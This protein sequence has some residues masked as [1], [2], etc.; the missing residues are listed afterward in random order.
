MVR[1]LLYNNGREEAWPPPIRIRAACVLPNPLRQ[2]F[3]SSLFSPSRPRGRGLGSFQPQGT[4]NLPV[5]TGYYCHISRG[6]SDRLSAWRAPMCIFYRMHI[7]ARFFYAVRDCFP[8]GHARGETIPQSACGRQLPL[9][10]GA[11]GYSFLP[12]LYPDERTSPDILPPHPGSLRSPIFPSK[13][14]ASALLPEASLCAEGAIK[15]VF[16]VTCAWQIHPDPPILPQQ[17]GETAP[18]RGAYLSKRSAAFLTASFPSR[19][20]HY[21][22]VRVSLLCRRRYRIC[23]S[24]DMRRGKTR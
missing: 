1:V 15:F 5:T 13:G 18:Q 17:N 3:Q 10:K 6:F 7:G 21:L 16:A 19:G 22:N 4:G 8:A 11:S 9:H 24:T 20:R 23:F 2:N 14:K 12:E